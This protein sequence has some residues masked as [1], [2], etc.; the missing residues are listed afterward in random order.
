MSIVRPRPLLKPPKQSRPSRPAPSVQPILLG[1]GV[2]LRNKGVSGVVIA[3]SPDI[4]RV[5]VRWDDTGEVTNCLKASLT[6][7]R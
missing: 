2:R 3:N 6:L 5:R 7:L 4:D 1:A